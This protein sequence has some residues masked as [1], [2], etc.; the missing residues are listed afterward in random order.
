[1]TREV[2]TNGPWH[3]ARFA[4]VEKLENR[5]T[6]TR[7][8][9][10]LLLETWMSIPPILLGGTHLDTA[11][12]AFHHFGPSPCSFTPRVRGDHGFVLPTDPAPGRPWRVT[13]RD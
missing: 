9:R 7:C 12:A 3:T 6:Y 13:S 2:D 1:L 10:D 8:S 4:Y 11:L 5:S